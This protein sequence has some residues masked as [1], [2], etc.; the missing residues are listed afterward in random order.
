MYTVQMSQSKKAYVD[1]TRPRG[2]TSAH[3][4]YTSVLRYRAP[5]GAKVRLVNLDTGKPI[6]TGTAEAG[7]LRPH[8][9]PAPR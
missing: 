6:R 1:V 4:V 5:Q 8:W 2:L 3:E 9:D 7:T